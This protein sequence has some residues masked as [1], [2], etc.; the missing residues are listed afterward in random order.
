LGVDS[1]SSSKDILREA[2]SLDL[3][4]LLLFRKSEINHLA[5]DM[6]KGNSDGRQLQ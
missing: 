3:E 2:A 4:I 6:E 5:R 1:R